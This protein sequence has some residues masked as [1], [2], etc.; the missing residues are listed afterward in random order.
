L[1]SAGVKTLKTRRGSQ[2]QPF[3]FAF[4]E[5]ARD[6]VRTDYAQRQLGDIVFVELPKVGQRVEAGE[7]FGTVESVMAVSTVYA[8]VTG[9]VIEEPVGVGLVSGD[10]P[11]VPG[12]QGGRCDDP[13]GLQRVGQQPGQRGQGRSV[14]PSP[15][16]PGHVAAQCCGFLARDQDFDVRG[17][18]AVGEELELAE[19]SD[20]GQIPQPE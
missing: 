16:R 18:G 12:Q 10:Q 15:A 17:R 19:G 1:P 5:P 9:Q 7:E 13:W 6:Q 14:R 4:F 11:A 3:R 20:C 8:P 2:W